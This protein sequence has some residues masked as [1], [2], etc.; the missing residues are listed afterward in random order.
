[1]LIESII[2]IFADI[3]GEFIH[4]IVL[5]ACRFRLLEK[6]VLQIIL[7]SC[8]VTR[9]GMVGSF[10]EASVCLLISVRRERGGWMRGT[11]L[12]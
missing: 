8:L 1:M 12:S 10:D 3:F 7:F 6:L 4:S 9:S 2:R 11:S 5:F